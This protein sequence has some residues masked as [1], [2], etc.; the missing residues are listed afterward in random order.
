MEGRWWP[1]L[2]SSARIWGTDGTDLAAEAQL[3]YQRAIR[4]QREGD[5]ARYGE[6]FERLGRIL[7]RLGSQPTE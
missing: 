6:E 3:H 1:R 5:W 7:E 2:R 4:A